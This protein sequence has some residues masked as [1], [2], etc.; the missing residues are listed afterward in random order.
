MRVAPTGKANNGEELS[1][2]RQLVEYLRDKNDWVKLGDLAKELA[3]VQRRA[4]YLMGRRPGKFENKQVRVGDQWIQ[5]WRYNEA[6]IVLHFAMQSM[7]RFCR[8]EEQEEACNDAV[9][10][11]MALWRVNDL[12]ECPHARTRRQRKQKLMQMVQLNF[13]DFYWYW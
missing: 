6:P 12:P 13:F 8:D 7:V 5:Y 9:G 10:E 11:Q 3:L 1:L 2:E 4:A